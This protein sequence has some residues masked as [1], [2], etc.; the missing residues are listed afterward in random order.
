MN[1]ENELREALQREPA[2]A[3]FRAKVL[4][5]TAATSRRPWILAVAAAVA[6]AVAVPV[7]FQRR[8]QAR[9]IRARDDLALALNITRAKLQQTRERIQRSAKHPL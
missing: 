1:I 6:L 7:E 2:P 9:A 8:E 3:D 5:R 4:A